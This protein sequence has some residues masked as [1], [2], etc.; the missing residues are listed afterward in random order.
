V[1]PVPVPVSVPVPDV[2]VLDDDVPVDDTLVPRP[3]EAGGATPPAL[4]TAE[5]P[6][7][8]L[9]FLSLTGLP[10]DFEV[11]SWPEEETAPVPD[12][13]PADAALSAAAGAR[14]RLAGAICACSGLG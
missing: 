12:R 2:S 9:S 7:V 14:L 10:V 5:L 6:P 11:T 13:G 1:V 3:V 8:G 4:I